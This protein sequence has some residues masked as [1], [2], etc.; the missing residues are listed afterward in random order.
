M[1]HEV[2]GDTNCKWYSRNS[3]QSIDTGSGGLGNKRTSGD[4][5]NYG[6][7]KIDQNTEKSLGD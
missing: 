1:E 4:H 5:P 6:I 2:D 7:V 3:H